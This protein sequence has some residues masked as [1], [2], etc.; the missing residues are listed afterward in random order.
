[1]LCSESGTQIGQYRVR[2]RLSGGTR[3]QIYKVTDGVSTT[4]LALKL[5]TKLSSDEDERERFRA[6]AKLLERIVHPNIVVVHASG[7]DQHDQPYIVMDLLQGQ[8]LK[9]GIRKNNL[10]PIR[11]R[12]LLALQLA[13][14]LEH[15]HYLDIIHRRLRPDH[16]HVDTSGRL[17]LLNAGISQAETETRFQAPDAASGDVTRAT[18]IYSFGVIMY[19]MLGGDKEVP[20]GSVP[21]PNVS[22]SLMDLLQRCT[23]KN[24]SYR[25]ESFTA[26]SREL[27]WWLADPDSGATATPQ[28]T[29]HPVRIPQRRLPLVIAAGSL[30]LL[31]GSAGAFLG[32]Y[33]LGQHSRPAASLVPGSYL[34]Q[35]R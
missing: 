28:A 15:L 32:G 20:V 33:R 21:L 13:R 35:K 3:A 11:A 17:R 4:V 6:E 24:P 1:M 34:S 5:L 10:G 26:I 12:V 14:A 8:T 27:E 9:E 31:L 23:A 16:I 22:R 30:V 19:E 25:P 29:G 18:D 7:Q 2:D